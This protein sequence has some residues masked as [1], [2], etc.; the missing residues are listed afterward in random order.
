MNLLLWR[1]EKDMGNCEKLWLDYRTKG[2]GN[3]PFREMNLIGLD[4]EQEAVDRRKSS[5]FV[6]APYRD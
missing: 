1:Q 2:W 5:S 4:R 6:F 3:R